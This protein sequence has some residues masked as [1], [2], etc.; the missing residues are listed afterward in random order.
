MT[1]SVY[2]IALSGLNAA[3]AGLSTTSNNIAN[4]NTDGYN[5]QKVTFQSRPATGG[6][7]G[8]IGKGVDIKSVERV[9]SSFIAGQQQKAASD[10]AFFTAKAEQVARIDSMIADDASGISSAL[11]IFFSAAQTLSTTPSDLAA[12]Q[13]FLSAAETLA[14]RFN[15]FNSI[16]DDLRLGTNLKV[17]DTVTQLNDATAQIAELN[18]RIVAAQSETFSGGPPNDLLDK[19]DQLIMQVAEQIQITRVNLQDGSVNL[20]LGNGQPLVVQTNQFPLVTQTDP[21]DIKNLLVGSEQTINGNKTLITLDPNTLGKG[22]LSGFLSFRETELSQFQN[23]VGLMAARFGEAVNTI[24][25]AGVD[26]NG[27]AGT[28]LFKF[29]S[30]TF[31]NGISRVA[32]NLNNSTTNPTSITFRSID[33]SRVSGVDYEV[34]IVGGAPMFRENGSSS[35]FA[36]ASLVTAMPSNYYEIRDTTGA[37]IVSFQLNNATP[38]DGDRFVLMPVREAAA[39]MSVAFTRGDLVAASSTTNPS[40]GNNGNIRDITALQTQR[41]LYQGN[42]ASGV[43]VS[44]AFNQMVSRVGNKTREFTVAAESRESVLNQ[45]K[46]TRD[47]LSGVNMDEEAANLIKFQQ[48]YQASGRVISLSK[49]MFELVLNI[50]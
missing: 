5:R 13:S 19:R 28:D 31:N 42:G 25:A 17:S 22:A 40:V 46:E 6:D 3:R 36:A 14:G 7:A 34:A 11:G 18:D 45:I 21:T 23:T 35:A 2:G 39:N 30:G 1:D 27:V 49:E 48:A 12:R 43:S 37:P 41:V 50:F 38:Q 32:P 4:A 8:F 24:Q 44:D 15:G 29:G 47:A 33:L 9:Y 20:F 10:A 16:M 26:L